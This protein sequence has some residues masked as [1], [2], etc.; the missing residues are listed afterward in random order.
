L[1]SYHA[2]KTV[3][4]ILLALIAPSSPWAAD[5][6]A[7]SGRSA[8]EVAGV[9]GQVFRMKAPQ[10]F[11]PARSD[12]KGIVKWRKDSA[13]IFAVVGDLK[14][15]TPGRLFKELYLAVKKNKNFEKVRKARIRG[16]RAFV[17]TEK[18]QEDRERIRTMRLVVISPNKIINVDF[19]APAENFERY[20]KDFRSALK[21]FRL[22]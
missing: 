22:L 19:S 2:L 6:K 12:R 5:D 10:G 11:V 17:Y 7:E 18:A 8:K 4:V 1:K 20:K 15:R 21:S 3:I 13:E 16:G 9:L 14:S